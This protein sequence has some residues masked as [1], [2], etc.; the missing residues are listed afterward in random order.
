MVIKNRFNIGQIVYLKTD[1]EQKGRIITGIQIRPTGILY[2]LQFSTTETYHYDIEIQEDL[3]M[4]K[5]L[6]IQNGKD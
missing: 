6:N 3:D 5:M 2:I 1:E 4:L